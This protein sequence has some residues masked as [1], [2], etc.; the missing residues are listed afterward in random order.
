MRP[1][2]QQ[3][4]SGVFWDL[5]EMAASNVRTHPAPGNHAGMKDEKMPE[6]PELR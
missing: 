4:F 5:P 1:Q 6:A 2:W 3:R